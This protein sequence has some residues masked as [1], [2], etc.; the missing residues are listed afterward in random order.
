[1]FRL[2]RIILYF[3]LIGNCIALD[4]EIIE[5]E[6]HLFYG[7]ISLFLILFSGFCSGATQGLLSIDQITIEVKLRK[8]ASRILSVIQ[9]HHLLLSTLLVANSLAN[10]SLPIFIKKSTGDWIALLISV[11]LVVLFGEIF[12]SA[13]MTGKHQL[14]IASFITP[15][16]QFLI[17]ILYL[18][19]Y[20]LSLILDKVL[21]TKCKRYHLEYIRQLMEI[22]KQ[23]DVIKPEELKIIVSVMEL[24]NKYVINYIKPLHN[25][26]YIQQDEPFCKRLIRRLKVK[27]YSMIP[28]IENNCVIGLFKSKDLITLDESNYGQLVVELVK[29]YQPLI[30]SGDTTML[31]L[32]LMFQKYKTNIAFAISQELQGMITL[33]DLFNEILDD[34]YLDEDV[35]GTVRIESASQQQ[36]IQTIY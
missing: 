7:M 31:D 3:R 29:V 36:S 2:F 12:P 1:M 22:C 20:P 34:V 33:R 4:P 15:Y 9:E 26:C 16:I 21:G 5:L 28:I 11:I 17:S 18:I 32:L 25:V 35:H 8:W 27:E 24:R 23:Q 6:D 10:E 30:I 19:C 14:S 13:I